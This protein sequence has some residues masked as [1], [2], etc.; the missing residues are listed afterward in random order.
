MWREPFDIKLTVEHDCL[1]F[2]AAWEGKPMAIQPISLSDEPEALATA[3]D[4]LAAYFRA[5]NL[6]L[7]FAG[8]EKKFADFLRERFPGR[9]DITA[10][11]DNFDYVYE[12]AS[13][14]SLAGRKYHSKKNH[15]NAF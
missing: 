14:I 15:L 10:D 8:L 11:R 13:L 7:N 5:H 2:I 9:F 6:P 3:V 1:Y 4:N 12:S